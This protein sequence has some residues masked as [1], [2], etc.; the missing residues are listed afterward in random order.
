MSNLTLGGFKIVL[1]G[2]TG[3]GKTSLIYSYACSGVA[4]LA[5]E[6]DELDK[7]VALMLRKKM[8]ATSGMDNLS[9]FV[10]IGNVPMRIGIWDTGKYSFILILILSISFSSTQP[11]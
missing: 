9:A 10:R 3:S 1:V 4:K 6:R 7:K 11:C 2:D 5:E 8:T